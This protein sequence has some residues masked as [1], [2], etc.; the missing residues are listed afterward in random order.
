MAIQLCLFS[1]KS[2]DEGNA[3]LTGCFEKVTELYVSLWI[4]T[5][6]DESRELLPY[7]SVHFLD[8]RR[9][10][11]RM[12]LHTMTWAS[13]SAPWRSIQASNSVLRAALTVAS[14]ASRLASQSTF[15]SRF[16]ACMICS[17]HVLGA[18]WSGSSC[19]CNGGKL[20][21]VPFCAV[22]SM[23]YID[24]EVGWYGVEVGVVYIDLV[25]ET[26][27]VPLCQRCKHGR[28]CWFLIIWLGPRTTFIT[29]SGYTDLR[30]PTSTDSRQ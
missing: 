13:I 24:I 3:G 18:C 14:P 30:T 21:L 6:A 16:I 2:L 1:T 26:M 11:D 5:E 25:L 22:P 9:D 28:V 20:A 12:S 17:S 7:R 19:S 23:S 10:F 29:S 4:Y 8:L 27:G 15:A